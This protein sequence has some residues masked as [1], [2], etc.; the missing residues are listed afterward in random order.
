MSTK[1][2]IANLKAQ[3]ADLESK[4]RSELFGERLSLQR[5][6]R[7]LD[8]ELGHAPAQPLTGNRRRR[9]FGGPTLGT[10]IVNY[11]Y[12]SERP[13]RLASI[14][15]A[16]GTSY[17]YVVTVVA[18]MVKRGEIIRTGERNRYEYSL[19]VATNGSGRSIAEHG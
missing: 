2:Q 14:I 6:M 19:P 13:Q 15:N 5:R 3:L 17:S 4:R 12:A 11:L 18:E 1:E 9:Y 16:T 10:K 7:E 8:H